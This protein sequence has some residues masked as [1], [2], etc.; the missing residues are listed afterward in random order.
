MAKTPKKKSEAR[1]LR[2]YLG[3]SLVAAVFVGLFVQGGV[4]DINTTLIW[5]GLT[6]I[7]SLVTIATLALTVKENPGDPNE[8]MLK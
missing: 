5:S 2:T 3:L 4:R 7:I 1:S 6:F 8:P